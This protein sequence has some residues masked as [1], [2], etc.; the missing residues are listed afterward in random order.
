MVVMTAV[1]FLYSWD[2]V[3]MT[4]VT[5]LHYYAMALLEL[6]LEY[7]CHIISVSRLT[8]C[9]AIFTHLYSWNMCVMATNHIH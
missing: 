1:T 3:G 9:I 5:Y 8:T 4:P 2:M 7:G 6:L